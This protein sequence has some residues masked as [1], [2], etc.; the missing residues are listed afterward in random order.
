VQSS[1][2]KCLLKF[3]V[4]SRPLNFVLQQEGPRQSENDNLAA[5]VVSIRKGK[6]QMVLCL[7]N[8]GMRGKIDFTLRYKVEED[9]G[10][11]APGIIGVND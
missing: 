6:S 3:Q 11:V 10:G 8:M 1:D 5:R 4:K 2:D 9:S 7:G